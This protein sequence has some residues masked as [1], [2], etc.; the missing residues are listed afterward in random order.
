MR[1][2]RGL[3]GLLAFILLLVVVVGTAWEQQPHGYRTEENPV[4]VFNATKAFRTVTE[5]AQRPHAVGTA[6]HDRVR[7][8]LVGELRKLGMQTEVRSGIGQWPTEF[9]SGELGIGRVENIVGRLAGNA[10]TGT[11]YLV[12]HYDSV[13]SGPGANDDGV[14]VAAILESVRA[15]TSSRTPVLRNNLVVLLSD[16]EEPGLLGSEAFVAA[17]DYDKNGVIVNHDARGAGG[18]AL[19]W[20]ITRPDGA[21]AQAVADAIPHPNSDSMTTA[22][23]GA[24]TSSNTDYAS[25]KP[26]GLRVLDW[27]YAGR[28]AYYHNR[29]DDPEHVNLATLQ[30]LGE[31]TLAQTREFGNKDLA[32]V[33][34]DDSNRAYFALPFGVLVVVPVWVIIALAVV[35]VLAVGWVIWQVRRNGETSLKRVFLSAATALAAV[36][37]AGAV[38][39]GL[40]VGVQVIRPSYKGMPIDPYRPEFYQA[41]TIVLSAA[42]LIGWYVF[43][44]KMFDAT[45]AGLGMLTGVAVLGAATAAVLPAA[46]EVIVVPGTLAAIGVALTF[47]TPQQWRLPILTVFLIPAAL[48]LGGF[49]WT[50]VQAGLTS[51]PFLAAPLIVLLGGL[52]LLTLTHAWPQRRSWTIPVTAVLLTAALTAAGLVVDRVD[53]QHPRMSQLIY[54]LNAE[55]HEARWLSSMEPDDWTRNFVSGDAPEQPF[56]TL[57]PKAISSGSAPAQ[58]LAAPTAEIL[59]DTTEAGQRKVHLRLRSLRGANRIDLLWDAKPQSL[60][61]AGRDITSVPDKGFHFYALPA[62]GI[63]VELV[64]PAGPLPLRLIDFTWLADSGVDAYRTP[65]ADTYFRQDTTSAV[66]TTVPLNG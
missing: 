55:T 4:D 28:S 48:F 43:A 30:Q 63:E 65:P 61:V 54:A 41:A 46:A 12:A 60:K 9:K 36:P 57:W 6:E 64:A 20:R 38:T 8:Y 21:L 22:L 59:S 58:S 44:R 31:N 10:P 29:L 47:V 32:T 62:E 11:V 34:A 40:W 45:A 52:L 35:M 18:P 42:V 17:G 14:G 49:T 2:G 5:I 13:P 3:S 51:A 19:L 56:A 16:G 15:F 7:D 66:F 23:A 33:T 25:F 1:V 37:L 39:Y 26:A 27:A 50:G 24:E 53:D